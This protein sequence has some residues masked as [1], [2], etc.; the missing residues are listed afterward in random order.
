MHFAVLKVDKYN[1]IKNKILLADFK[2]TYCY[3]KQ[4]ITYLLG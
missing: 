1:E 2:P 4:R 3:N